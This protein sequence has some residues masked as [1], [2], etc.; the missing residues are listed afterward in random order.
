M[1]TRFQLAFWLFAAWI[2]VGC[3]RPEPNAAPLVVF[4]ASSTTEAFRELAV[5]F[6]DAHPDVDVQLVFAG[7]QTLR[8]QL[9]QGARSDVIASANASHLRSLSEQGV[10]T[11][12]GPFATNRLVVIVPRG[13]PAG[14]ETFDDLPNAE[15]IV[16]GA[17]SV[18]VG[19][20]TERLFDDAATRWGQA[21]TA[22]LRR[23][24]VSKESNVRL[25]RAKVDLG[26]A[27]A[28]VVYA[29]D[30]IDHDGVEMIPV[31]ED[32]S[33]RAEYFIGRVVR[34]NAHPAA[35][36]WIEF[37]RGE[38]ARGILAR[39]GFGPTASR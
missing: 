30:A 12:V 25:V 34:S 3:T 16:V 21:K 9:E 2:A 8:L 26:E 10:V 36:S 17:A 20:Y 38:R 1:S 15:R 33:V 32:L 22:T 31:P 6:E 35:T 13:N 23:H 14:L 7:S 39:H 18:P 4:A 24:I 19:A 11:D 29:T 27:D 5:A 37:L 28:A